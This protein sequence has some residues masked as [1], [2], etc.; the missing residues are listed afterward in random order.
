MHT[1]PDQKGFRA[2]AFESRQ[3]VTKEDAAA[4]KTRA[5]AKALKEASV[6]V[7]AEAEAVRHVVPT[8]GDMVAGKLSF[9]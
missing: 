2:A 9:E 1:N 8:M 5:Q 6:R 3:V 7:S 4:K